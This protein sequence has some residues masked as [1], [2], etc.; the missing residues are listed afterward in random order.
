MWRW[1]ARHHDPM[2]LV[3]VSA[4][5]AYAK[6][7]EPS[8]ETTPATFADVPPR[9]LM[10]LD[11]AQAVL[12]PAPSPI[13]SPAAPSVSAVG[14]LWVTEANV[15]FVPGPASAKMSGF[16]VAYTMMAIHAVSRSVPSDVA[17]GFYGG[18]CVY[19]QLDE[20]SEHEQDQDDE[21]DEQLQELFFLVKDEAQRTYAPLTAV[22]QLY[23][24]LSEGSALHPSLSADEMNSH[25]LAAM[26]SLL[27]SGMAAHDTEEE[28]D[29]DEDA[30]ATQ[31]RTGRVRP[32]F[33][34][35]DARFRPY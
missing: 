1:L 35:P 19:V 20:S 16:Q 25:P 5:P 12:V 2:P 26:A 18:A 23:A 11:E 34:S 24:A 32:D 29:A 17:P 3:P 27:G 13:A 28:N 30:S 22:D 9:L 6:S 7:D 21:D 33:Q 10:H 8:P 4:A 31:A 14:D 15:T